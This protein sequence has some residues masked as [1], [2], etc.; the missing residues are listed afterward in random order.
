MPTPT[1]TA[2]ANITLGSSA[3]SVSFSSIPSS[4]RDLVLIENPKHNSSS[5]NQSTLI[6]LN[7]D[8]GANYTMVYMAGNISSSASQSGT[9]GSATS[10]WS[11]RFNNADG[12]NAITQFLDYSATDKHKTVLSRG[13]LGL[14]AGLAVVTFVNR[15]A[16]TSAITSMLLF[17]EDGGN[18]AAGSTFALY[19]IAS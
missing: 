12:N 6:R 9:G 18:Y 10:L 11:G 1:Y 5:T 4:F 14:V 2:L 8:S 17:P 15:W 13:N 19:G 16:N 3:S 7:G